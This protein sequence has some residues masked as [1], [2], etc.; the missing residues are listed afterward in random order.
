MREIAIFGTSKN[1]IFFINIHVVYCR[2]YTPLSLVSNKISFLN[3]R[4]FRAKCG[5]VIFLSFC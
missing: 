5:I 4:K 2:Y 1:G 3:L